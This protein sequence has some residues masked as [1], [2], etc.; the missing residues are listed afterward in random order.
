MTLEGQLHISLIHTFTVILH[1]NQTGTAFFDL[2]LDKVSASIQTILDV[3]KRQEQERQL[4]IALFGR[5]IALLKE[6]L[7]EK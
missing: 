1:P 3:Y 6:E 2:N 7:D 4:G 5:Y